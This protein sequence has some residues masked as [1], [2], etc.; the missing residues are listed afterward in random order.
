MSIMIY[1]LSRLFRLERISRDGEPYLTRVHL[2]RW[3]RGRLYLHYFHR[4]D[5]EPYNHDHPWPFWSLILWGGYWEIT[6]IPQEERKFFPAW[7]T[8]LRVWYPPLWLL[9]R[10]AEWQHRVVLPEGRRA[11]TLVWVGRKERSWGFICKGGW[12]HWKQ[13]ESQG[14]CGEQ[15]EVGDHQED[16]QARR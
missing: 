2:L 7:Q 14:G 15:A 12:V 8:E 6:P 13:H 5:A 4:G 11:L 10:P 1:L 3:W 9:R 16:P